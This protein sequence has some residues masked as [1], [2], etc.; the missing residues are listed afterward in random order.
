MKKFGTSASKVTT[1]RAAAAVI[2]K[3]AFSKI[4]AVEGITLTTAM[5]RRSDEFDRKGL[6]PEQ[7]RRAIIKAHKG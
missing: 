7:R 5:K 2:G 4:S 3:K 6:S 1:K